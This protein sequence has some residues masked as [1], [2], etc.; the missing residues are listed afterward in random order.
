MEFSLDIS[1]VDQPRAHVTSKDLL[2]RMPDLEVRRDE[3]R[4]KT[5]LN[6]DVMLFLG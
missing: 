2:N 6:V 5:N 3:K 1:C 4:T